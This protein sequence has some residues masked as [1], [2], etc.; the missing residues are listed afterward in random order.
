MPC[1]R[2]Q[3]AIHHPSYTCIHSANTISLFACVSACFDRAV[4]WHLLQVQLH[5][6]SVLIVCYHMWTRIVLIKFPSHAGDYK[7]PITPSYISS[8]IR[9]LD[10]VPQNRKRPPRWRD[11]SGTDTT[12]QCY[13]FRIRIRKDSIRCFFSELLSNTALVFGS[14]AVCSISP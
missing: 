3:V 1:Q 11:R 9:K 2:Q 14:V 8:L 4:T 12:L 5:T 13:A 10:K 7:H 6:A